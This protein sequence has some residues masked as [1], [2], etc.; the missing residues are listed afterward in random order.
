M[1]SPVGRPAEED[2]FA[3]RYHRV[4]QDLD[5][6]IRSGTWLPGD[7]ILSEAELCARYG[8]SRGTIQRAVREL[9]EQ[10][11]LRRERG[12]ATYVSSPRLEGGVLASY[13]QSISRPHDAG[14]QV[15]RCECRE[16]S[17]EIRVVMGLEEGVKVYELERLRFVREVPLSLQLSYLAAD[18]FPELEC[19]ELGANH[20]F[21]ILLSKYNIA[22]RRAE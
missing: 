21:D 8:V 12:R 11:L 1:L 3:P 20:L 16:P 4:Y 17:D 7:S 15:P 22:F 19:C 5:L 10:G 18:V 14:A 9:V 2:S 13:E 6:R